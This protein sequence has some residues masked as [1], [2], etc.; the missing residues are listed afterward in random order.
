MQPGSQL[1]KHA[2]IKIILWTVLIN[3][4]LSFS[5][6]LSAKEV[7]LWRVID[8]PPFYILYG[9]DKGQGIYDKLIDKIANALPEY[10]HRTIVMN[11]Q[12]VLAE[13]QKGTHVCHPSAL[14]DTKAI[15]SKTN[16]L[17]LPH[18]LIVDKLYNK[19]GKSQQS[20]SLNHL[21]TEQKINVG[22]ANERYNEQ[23]NKILKQHRKKS[24][25]I[26]QN[27][28]NS[29][30]KMFFRNRVEALIEY[31]PVIAYSK[32]ILNEKMNHTSFAITELSETNYLP[33][34]FAC[35]D[36]KWGQSVIDKINKVL[37]EES[38]DDDYLDFRLKW[39]DAASRAVLKQYYVDD[40]LKDKH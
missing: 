39:Y 40:Y 26:N 24:N 23:L 19:I 12:R 18:R 31:T 6:K 37:V 15:L 30:V 3:L 27:N 5:S 13:L 9:K 29:L 34:H 22:I 38:K 20:V 33:V 14:S 35:P 2:S 21:L 36:N 10:E 8:W 16:S 7:L 1:L 17:L 28:Y 25:L 11:T 32:R 4:F